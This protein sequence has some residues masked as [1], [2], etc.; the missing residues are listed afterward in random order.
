M[1]SLDPSSDANDAATTPGADA[2][3]IVR[4]PLV[5]LNWQAMLVG[6]PKRT[7][8]RGESILIRASW[9]EWGLYSDARITSEIEFGPYRLMLA[10]PAR[11]P[12]VGQAELSLVL[13]ADD[14]LVDPAEHSMDLEKQDVDSYAGGDLGEQAAS[15]LAL[16]LGRRLRSGGVT[17]QGYDKDRQGK[18]FYGWHHAPGL[19]APR[20]EPM[21]PGIA[22]E[23]NVEA[24]LPY[25][26]AYARSMASKLLSY[27]VRRTSSL[28]RCGGLTLIRASP[29]LSSSAPLRRRRT[30]GP[31]TSTLTRSSS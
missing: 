27:S 12:R 13:R 17:R 23:I 1:P 19:A 29:G 25:L 4:G 30:Y 5:W 28:M 16:A 15:L 31:R 11:M 22:D 6:Q 21:L 14:H 8:S 2:D 10:F 9:Q 18:P 26:E 3:V 20:R 24:A 7:E